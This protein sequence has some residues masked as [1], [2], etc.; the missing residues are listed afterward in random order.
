MNKLEAEKIVGNQPQYALRN[1]QRALESLPFM[2]DASEWKRLEAC[3]TLRNVP[4]ARRV[5]LYKEGE[6]L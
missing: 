1:M 2:N 5:K 4:K 6:S 3:Y